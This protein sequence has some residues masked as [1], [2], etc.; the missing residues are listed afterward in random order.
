MLPKKKR[1]R[2]I[3]S[4]IHC[5]Q[6]REALRWPEPLSF[7]EFPA[8]IPRRKLWLQVIGREDW[9]PGD[10]AKVCSMHFQQD[11][12]RETA[13]AKKLLKNTAVPTLYL[14]LEAL[15]KSPELP[16]PKTSHL[17]KPIEVLKKNQTTKSAD[18][19]QKRL[20]RLLP[21][22]CNTNVTCPEVPF[23]RPHYPQL[24]V[25][26]GY[27][28][29]IENCLVDWCR[30]YRES[31]Q[32]TEP[33]SFH[34]FPSD[35]IRKE[36]WLQAL[37]Q[38]VN[39]MH[40]IMNSES[41][42]CSMHFEHDDFDEQGKRSLKP[43]AVPSLNLFLNKLNDNEMAAILPHDVGRSGIERVTSIQGKKQISNEKIQERNEE[44]C[45]ESRKRI[46]NIIVVDLVKDKRMRYPTE[47]TEATSI[48]VTCTSCLEM[49]KDLREVEFQ[50][51]QVKKELEEQKKLVDNLK[52][53]IKKC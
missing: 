35:E 47:L 37:G 8:D 11:C 39:L 14:I 13:L 44:E 30:Q 23:S 38:N 32:W 18:L 15:P 16:E 49:K 26:D 33:L 25:P 48:E 2:N 20:Y 19:P 7:H 46:S 40:K 51:V 29:K 34:Q 9:K 10:K 24:Q 41:R 36:Q 53:Q 42:V 1:E 17:S 6:Y 3:C 4:V 31:N 50:L 28:S 5:R 12:Y 43:D 22:L 52:K 45:A 21:K 27:S